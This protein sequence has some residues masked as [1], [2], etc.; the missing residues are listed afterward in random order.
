MNDSNTVF[1][2]LGEKK[3]KMVMETSFFFSSC[4]TQQQKQRRGLIKPIEMVKLEEER[5]MISL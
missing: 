3:R 4:K 5:V 2:Y 1:I